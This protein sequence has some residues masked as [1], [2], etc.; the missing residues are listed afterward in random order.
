MTTKSTSGRLVVVAV[1]CIYPPTELLLQFLTF[2]MIGPLKILS[3][4]TSVVKGIVW[5]PI[6]TFLAT[7]VRIVF[8]GVFSIYW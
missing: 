6:G 1:R 8:L 7:Q 2:F 3:G 5:D 4:H